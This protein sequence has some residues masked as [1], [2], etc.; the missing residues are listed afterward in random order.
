MRRGILSRRERVESRQRF[1]RWSFSPP[2]VALRRLADQLLHR[3]LLNLYVSLDVQGLDKLTGVSGP[4]LFIANHTSY[5]DQP[6]VMN[7]LP[8]AWRY[9][10]ATAAWAEFFFVNFRTPAQHL[11]KRLT[12]EYTTT[13]MGV[14]PLPQSTGFR[15]SLQHM[16]WLADH[17]ISSLVFPEGERTQNGQ[18]LPFQQGLGI[19]VRELGVPVVPVRIAGL[20]RVL[21]RDA[22]WPK[23]GRVTVT[24]GAPL[25]FPGTA[26]PEMIVSRCR[27]AISELPHG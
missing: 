11:W 13:F 6:C 26:A 15:R 21:P 25:L 5:L 1:R 20:E 22:R 17:G 24:F 14:F 19:I 27:Q 7:A 12:Y 23:R 8:P 18:L 9:R 2:V 3:P 10:T 16:G 4:V